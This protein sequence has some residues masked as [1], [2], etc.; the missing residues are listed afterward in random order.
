MRRVTVPTLSWA[1][2]PEPSPDD[3]IDVG[4]FDNLGTFDN[5]IALTTQNGADVVIDFGGGDTLT[6][7]NVQKT[8]LIRDDFVGVR[9]VARTSTTRVA[10]TSCGGTTT[11]GC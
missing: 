9:A 7:Q 10:A 3:K 6:L 1:S 4:G 2:S 11:A 5:L 8:S